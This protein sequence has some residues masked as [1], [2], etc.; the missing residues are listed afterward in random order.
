MVV[1]RRPSQ[2]VELASRD[3]TTPSLQNI[4]ATYPGSS[5]DNRCRTGSGCN[6]SAKTRSDSADCS[7]AGPA[8]TRIR[9]SAHAG[10][11]RRSAG[12]GHC[13]I[14]HT[15]D[16][17][18]RIQRLR[19][20]DVMVDRGLG[21]GRAVGNLEMAGIAMERIA[22]HVTVVAPRSVTGFTGNAEIGHVSLQ[23]LHGI[24]RRRLPSFPGNPGFE[25]V[26]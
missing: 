13:G 12:N 4:D 7:S 24:P 3:P 11:E 21:C 9:V 20:H 19:L 6:G 16:S 8:E 17:L 14:D 10:T 22:V 23:S 1:A 15:R 25:P 26:A 2:S 5:I 18:G